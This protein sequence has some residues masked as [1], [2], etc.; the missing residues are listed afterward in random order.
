MSLV[1]RGWSCVLLAVVAA[2]CSTSTQAEVKVSAASSLRDVLVELEAAFEQQHP[3]VDVVLNFAGSATL[4]EQI[5]GGAPIDVFA[6]ADPDNMVAV[7]DAGLVNGTPEVFALNT[8]AIAFPPGNPGGVT[9][10][11]DLGRGELFVGLCAE[12]VP[13]GSLA[14]EVLSKA[15]VEVSAATAEPSVVSLLT[16]IEA[17]ELDA[18][19]VYW[20]D[21]INSGGSVE[22]LLI[23]P[24]HNV[25]SQLPVAD[26]GGSGPEAREFVEFVASSDAVAILS[27]YGFGVP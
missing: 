2:A 12:S 27:E 20:T 26:L 25:V 10:L 8:M 15:G 13:C 14:L 7:V 18:G 1:K 19:I 22:G 21:V 17:G 11:A 9:G 23:P 24:G 5:V 4:R 6:S 3:E 16:K